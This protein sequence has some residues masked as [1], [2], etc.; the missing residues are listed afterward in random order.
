[1]RKDV[2][3]RKEEILELISK[4]TSISKMC[5]ILNCNNDTLKR[6]L[7]KWGIVYAGNPGSKGCGSPLKKSAKDFLF[8]N[9]S[10]SSFKL[11]NRLFEEGLKERKCEI[12]GIT[13]WMGQPAPLELDHIDG[14]HYNNEF[15]NLRILCSNCHALTP[16]N[17]GKNRNKK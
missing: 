3:A 2:E 17:S 12:C 9:S 7:R 11:K 10:I 14:E 15:E 13:E 5:V 16:T 4:H 1:M 8:K 6:L